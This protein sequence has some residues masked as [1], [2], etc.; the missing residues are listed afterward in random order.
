MTSLL[1]RPPEEASRLIAL[2]LLLRVE[3][4]AERL[5]AGE[6][7]DALHDFRV[8]VRRLRSVLRAYR[9]PL[10]GS[11]KKRHRRRL[12]DL[13][14]A[15][16]PGRD[17]EVAAAWIG[18][19]RGEL[20]AEQRHG[21]DWLQQRYLARRGRG[22]EEVVRRLDE[23]LATVAGELRDAL[24]VY[25]RQVRLDGEGS[26]DS[27][28]ELVGAEA[29][30]DVE[31]LA[32]LLGAIGSAA[33]GDAVHRARLAAKRLRYLLEPLAP[34]LAAVEPILADLRRLQDLLGGLNDARVFSA[35]LAAA[36]ETA[37]RQRSRVLFAAA[38]GEAGEEGDDGAVPDAAE[39]WEPVQGLLELA[40]R[41]RRRRDALFAELAAGWLGEDGDE[42]RRLET[43]VGELAGWLEA[44][45]SPPPPASAGRAP[46]PAP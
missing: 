35:D 27:F 11:V 40:R 30:R 23:E 44:G 12:R 31:R 6:D 16:G 43:A 17:A 19:Q 5:H 29:R 7:G 42:R 37:A 3:N 10:R 20:S 36:V 22:Q 32:D 15:T 33:D 21:A 1:T 8:A 25:T 2:S 9:E 4:A 14:R 46:E 45:F 41:N 28:G 13:A 18:D 24:G 38:A 39:G 26:K 34:D